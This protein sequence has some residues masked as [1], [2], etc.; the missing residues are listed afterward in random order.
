MECLTP[1][2]QP[3][4]TPLPGGCDF[5]SDQYSDDMPVITIKMAIHY[6]AV[7][8][9]NFYDGDVND[10]NN[11]NGTTNAIL[12]IDK[13][14]E[15]LS[16]IVVNPIQSEHYL[17]DSRI[18]FEVVPN[19]ED[20]VYFW[21]DESD[22]VPVPG[23]LN[24]KIID[25]F[26]VK[27][28]GLACSI[29]W[30]CDNVVMWGW[31]SSE[32][33]GGPWFFWNYA[34]LLNHEVGHVLGLNHSF[35]SLAECSGVDIDY[36]LESN[37]G[38]PWS[39][40]GKNTM[41][42]VAEQKALSPCQWKH[43]YTNLYNGTFSFA[44]IDCSE[45]FS[46]IVITQDETWDERTIVMSDVR[47]L[48]GNT[49]TIKCKVELNSSSSIY[50]ES[51]GKLV[52]DGGYLT[53]LS[54][55]DVDSWSGIVV[56]GGNSDFDVKMYN[57]AV[58]E[59]VEHTAVS[60]FPNLPWP[61][62]GNGILH[63]DNTTFNNCN[64]MVEFISFDPAP[65][66]SH[67]SN[68]VQNGGKWG[69]TNWNCQGI[70]VTDN[71]FNDITD[72]CIGSEAGSFYIDGNEFHSG[73][74]DIL[75]LNTS[76]GYPSIIQ[77][78]DF[79]GLQTGYRGLG[80]TIG[81]NEINN[82]IFHAGLW[83]VFMD[84][85][86]NYLVEANEFNA[87]FTGVVSISN[88]NAYNEV[89]RNDFVGNDYGLNALFNNSQYKFLENCFQSNNADAYILGD[90]ADEMATNGN[91][92]AG[93][94][95]SHQG[96]AGSGVKDIDGNPDPFNYYEPDP[97]G[98]P[99]CI[100]AILA[101]PNVTIVHAPYEFNGCLPGSPGGLYG[102]DN[103]A[104]SAESQILDLKADEK[105][106]SGNHRFIQQQAQLIDLMSN[107]KFVG[108]QLNENNI[109]L[110]SGISDDDVVATYSTYIQNNDLVSARNYI[111][112]V[113]PTSEQLTD[114]VTT[115]LLNLERLENGPYYQF[116]A[117]QLAT[118]LAIANK[119]HPY[120]AY[121]KSLYYVLTEVL[122]S[123]ELPV[124]LQKEA[125]IRGYVKDLDVKSMIYPNPFNEILHIDIG[126]YKNAD[127]KIMNFTGQ[128]VFEQVG[129]NQNLELATNNWIEGLYIITLSQE[130][131]VLEVKKCLLIK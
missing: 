42:Y 44:D 6:I 127:I 45:T 24:V 110:T 128:I 71:V 118:I 126:S 82:N 67:V 25:E 39:S 51:G 29:G 99:T 26:P 35:I 47:V 121:A 94:C 129:L 104:I 33:N 11:M 91:Q 116:D 113:V 98:A 50:V 73:L 75:Y 20:G 41:S 61:Q 112:A 101:H 58:I 38:D 70:V 86:N 14:N 49:L 109:A 117:Q 68:C 17:G 81:R 88:G 120:A 37:N 15:I 87:A 30:D 54:Q 9:G 90:V 114:F 69:I 76:A 84:G 40:G 93:N 83:N 100:N 28:R 103:S 62:G 4:T 119:Q 96:N 122:I 7:G 124:F 97:V 125:Q 21:D 23:V 105:E 43:I 53:S 106:G 5:I 1:F 108:N 13:S 130:N 31:Q 80:T 72:H 12:L 2:S 66:S 46:D 19:Y 52:I 16:N 107:E 64:R 78:N 95:F 63:A 55:C 48:S 3:Q 92:G 60:M 8:N 74:N 57:N 79:Y 27:L 59:N 89:V 115:Q 85:D 18:R 56:N 34:N 36:K 123:S 32:S 77:N 65:N 102:G 22:Y 131:D 10:W 111:E